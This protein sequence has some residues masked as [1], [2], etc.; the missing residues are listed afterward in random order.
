M[1][2]KMV[3]FYDNKY[4]ATGC[5]IC[6]EKQKIIWLLLYNRALHILLFL[7]KWTLQ[8]GFLYNVNN[9]NKD[10][11][12][13]CIGYRALSITNRGGPYNCLPTKS[14]HATSFPSNVEQTH[15]WFDPPKRFH[16]PQSF[17]ERLK[18]ETMTFSYQA[19]RVN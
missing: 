6:F 11:R 7:F 1:Y 9:N 17:R 18:F 15:L 4:H 2:F 12:K 3:F 8:S 10:S 5:K 19:P 14:G 16:V 13:T